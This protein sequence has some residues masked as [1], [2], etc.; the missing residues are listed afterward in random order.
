MWLHCGSFVVSIYLIISGF[1][2]IDI[3]S[4]KNAFIVFLIFVAVMFVTVFKHVKRESQT[5]AP[6]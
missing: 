4:L 6:I 3:E 5:D 2:K 1:I